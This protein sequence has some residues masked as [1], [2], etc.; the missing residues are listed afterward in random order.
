MSTTSAAGGFGSFRPF[1]GKVGIS[2]SA[3]EV[4]PRV[5][6]ADPASAAFE[7]RRPPS[8]PQATGLRSS[9]WGPSSSPS[10]GTMATRA[11]TLR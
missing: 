4:R 8:Y 7:A 9:A 11:E 2:A 6:Q 5:P 1:P 3:N 10:R